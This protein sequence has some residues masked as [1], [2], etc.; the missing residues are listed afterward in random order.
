MNRFFGVTL[1]VLALAIAIWPQYN[2]C[3][4]NGKSITTAAGTTV[5]MKCKWSAQAEIAVG[6]PLGV[7]GV[8]ALTSRRKES[9]RN[10]P[11]MGIVLGALA[12]SIPNNLIGVCSSAMPCNTVMRPSLIGLGSLAIVISLVGL[13]VSQRRKE[14]EI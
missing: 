8:V 10:L 13:V 1:I 12:I 5:P 2:T 4:R 14:A 11:V 3:E 9:M 7:L 6:V